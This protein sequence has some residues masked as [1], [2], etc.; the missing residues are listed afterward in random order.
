MKKLSHCLTV[1]LVMIMSLVFLT[2]CNELEVKTRQI[3]SA[4]NLDE[5]LL[6]YAET[7][8]YTVTEEELQK[9]AL[10]ALVSLNKHKSDA[11]CIEDIASEYKIID[12]ISETFTVPETKNAERSVLD[13]YK[14]INF[15]AYNFEN[16]V[17]QEKS[18]V[19][20][21]DDR[22]IGEI[23]AVADGEFN[24][25]D[26]VPFMDIIISGIEAHVNETIDAWNNLYPEKARST[27]SNS[28]IGESC[29]YTVTKAWHKSGY[30]GLRNVLLTNWNQS[31]YYNDYIKQAEGLGGYNTSYPAGCVAVTL[32]QIC[33]ELEYP[34]FCNA[35]VLKKLKETGCVEDWNGEYDYYHMKWRN[36]YE[37]AFTY[38][39]MGQSG[40]NS[41]KALLYDIGKGV[42]MDYELNLSYAYTSDALKWLKAAGFSCSNVSMY[43]FN[44]IKKSINKNCP[45]FIQAYRTWD[46]KINSLSNGHAWVID[47][48]V[49]LDCDVINNKTGEEF[50]ITENFVH[51][52][53]GWGGTCN[54]YY[55]DGIFNTCIGPLVKRQ[56]IMEGDESWEEI[57]EP[58]IKDKGGEN[59]KYYKYEIKTINNITAPAVIN[60][61]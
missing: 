47:D 30:E 36:H 9:D 29:D 49:L 32:A 56:D 40:R 20:S 17:T 45:V 5:K 10:T 39:E 1:S 38:N 18:F 24:P 31:P 27:G 54:G 14:D 13:S 58:N 16:T 43:Y 2:G 23:I 46:E 3:S 33:A 6:V 48:Y 51:C 57:Y 25:E 35:D 44:N 53:F 52:N 61:D 50:K 42:N 19:L 34:K 12:V 4:E 15:Y 21:C 28:F 7:G 59:N 11:R 22:R 26:D 60:N 41:V 8:N 55:R 37:H